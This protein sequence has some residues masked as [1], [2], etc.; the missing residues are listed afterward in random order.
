MVEIEQAKNDRNLSNTVAILG[1]GLATSQ[2]SSAVILAQ[3]PPDKDIPFYNTTAFQ[4]SLFAGIAASLSGSNYS[5]YPLFTTQKI[6]YQLSI[7]SPPYGGLR[8]CSPTHQRVR[9]NSNPKSKIQN[10]CIQ[11]PALSFPLQRIQ[12]IINRFNRLRRNIIL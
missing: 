9:A 10:P 2:L 11:L 8:N 6:I 3:K 12:R 5:F 7:F 1:V 4:S